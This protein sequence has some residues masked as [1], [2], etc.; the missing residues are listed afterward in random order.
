MDIHT[1]TRG[2]VCARASV[3]ARGRPPADQESGCLRPPVAR[4]AC[5]SSAMSSRENPVSTRS[6]VCFLRC[7]ALKR[8]QSRRRCGRVPAQ[9]WARLPDR[10]DRPLQ[11][12]GRRLCHPRLCGRQQ[13]RP[14]ERVL[15]SATQSAW[16]PAVLAAWVAAVVRRHWHWPCQWQELVPVPRLGLQVLTFLL[17]LTSSCTLASVIHE[18]FELES[19][20]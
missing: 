9:M 16:A 12:Y 11:D 8:S 19:T 13:R 4:Q 6:A 17:F 3:C 10:G 7:N 5:R 2:S 20:T 18:N 14:T 1:C 15:M